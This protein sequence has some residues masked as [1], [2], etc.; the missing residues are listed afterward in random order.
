MEEPSPGPYRLTNPLPCCMPHPGAYLNPLLPRL[1]ASDAQAAAQLP[2]GPSSEVS[3]LDAPAMESTPMRHSDGSFMGQPLM[4]LAS[5]EGGATSGVSGASGG[6]G[7]AAAGA[8]GCGA[9]TSPATNFPMGPPPPGHMYNAPYGPGYRFRHMMF[10]Y[11]PP[12]P[13]YYGQEG[14][15]GYDGASWGVGDHEPTASP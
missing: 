7:S 6:A 11:P 5:S 12:P 4:P 3:G 9:T 1:L 8:R 15:A 13:N 2:G 10:A 14:D